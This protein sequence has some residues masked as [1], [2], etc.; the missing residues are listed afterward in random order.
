MAQGIV[1]SIHGFE[2]FIR[3][4]RLGISHRLQAS[5][6]AVPVKFGLRAFKF[7][8]HRR[9]AVVRQLLDVLEQ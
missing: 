9:P 8:L 3:Y 6:K 7:S 4:G 1:A 2:L 5:E